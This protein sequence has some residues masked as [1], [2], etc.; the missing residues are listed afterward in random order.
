MI[1]NSLFYTLKGY[2]K[3]RLSVD[4]YNASRIIFE[5]IDTGLPIKKANFMKILTNITDKK[6]H[7]NPDRNNFDVALGNCNHLVKKLDT[8]VSGGII[9]KSTKGK[10]Y[11]SFGLFTEQRI[12]IFGEDKNN[13]T[14]FIF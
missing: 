10:V 14:K 3:L 6:T 2:I 8:D 5:I 9:I 4:N 7:E 13:E 1:N 11:F 12:T